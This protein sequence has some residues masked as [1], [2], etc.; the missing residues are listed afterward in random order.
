VGRKGRIFPRWGG[1]DTVL[2]RIVWMGRD[3]SRMR[4][5]E[6][7]MFPGRGGEEGTCWGAKRVGYITLLSLSTGSWYN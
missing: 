6:R 2:D 5:R 7:G 3:V 4:R 1:R